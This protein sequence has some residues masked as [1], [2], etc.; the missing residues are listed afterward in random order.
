[1]KR[2]VAIHQPNYIP[3]SGYFHKMLYSTDFVF[4]RNVEFSKGGYVNR[5]R[6]SMNE[7]P[8]WMTV[9]VSAGNETHIEYVNTVGDSWKNKH[10]KTIEQIYS[11]HYGF[12]K[13]F[14]LIRYVYEDTPSGRLCWFNRQLICFLARCLTSYNETTVHN[15]K[16]YDLSATDRLV[17]LCKD[18]N[19]DYYLSGESGVK[20]LDVKKFEENNIQILVQCI[21]EEIKTRAQQGKES[22]LSYIF[23]QREADWF[24]RL[25]N[26]I[27][28]VKL[29][30]SDGELKPV[31]GGRDALL[32]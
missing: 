8:I 26:E 16:L 25:A 28:D 27:F 14:P 22:I 4:L 13:Y 3:W 24:F 11:R 9:P 19:A 21:P 1:M 17:R 23:N 10:L 5:A 30:G 12:K 18:H 31:V 15:D 32:H 6:L 20:Y 29:L 2:I 7:V